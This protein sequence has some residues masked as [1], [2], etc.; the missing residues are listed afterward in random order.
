MASELAFL[1]QHF[2]YS[3][4]CAYAAIIRSS[5]FCF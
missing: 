4:C 2:L 1:G 5:L 3:W